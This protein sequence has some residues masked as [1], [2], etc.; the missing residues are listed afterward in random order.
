MFVCVRPV[1]ASMF[2]SVLL[3]SLYHGS[4]LEYSSKDDFDVCTPPWLIL[5]MEGGENECWV[6]HAFSHHHI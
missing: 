4:L 2:A 1:R 6:I 3:A 5:H